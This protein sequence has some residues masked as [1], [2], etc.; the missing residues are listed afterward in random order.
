MSR[1]VYVMRG[2]MPKFRYLR[3]LCGVLVVGL[4]STSMLAAEDP[5]LDLLDREAVKVDR[6][7]SDTF[8]AAEDVGGNPSRP[9]AS[10]ESFETLLRRQHVGTYS[11]YRRLPERSREEVYLDYRGGASIETLRGKIIDR[12]LHP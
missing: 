6:A 8:T 1:P 3:R 2:R 7:A 12:Y 10:Q 11:F 5:Y 9:V 4:F